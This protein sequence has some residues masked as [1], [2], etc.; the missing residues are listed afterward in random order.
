[1]KFCDHP[2]EVDGN[3]I[4]L[5]CDDDFLCHE[6]SKEIKEFLS[7]RLKRSFGQ[8]VDISFRYEKKERK[9]NKEP[10]VY[11]VVRK[12]KKRK[13]MKKRWKRHA[14]YKKRKR[15]WQRKKKTRDPSVFFGSNVE[16]QLCQSA[17]LW[18]KLEKS[19]SPV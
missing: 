4:V 2:F 11:T 13:K 1:M 9:I 5:T 16:G 19:L 12:K 18:T 6:K 14:R 15:M 8:E 3:S 7:K 10:E 17:I